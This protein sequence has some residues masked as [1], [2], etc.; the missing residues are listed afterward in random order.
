MVIS[1]LEYDRGV[2]WRPDC[3][4]ITALIYRCSGNR[5]ELL[6]AKDLVNKGVVYAQP[7]LRARRGV[8][9]TVSPSSPSAGGLLC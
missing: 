1:I 5:G 2:M 4:F 8:F 6:I 9:S 3:D 7:Y